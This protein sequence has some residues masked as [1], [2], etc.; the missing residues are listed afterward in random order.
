MPRASRTRGTAARSCCRAPPRRL[1]GDALPDGLRTVSLSGEHRLRDLGRPEALFQLAHP[2]LRR[3]FAPLRSLDAFPGNLPL[4]VSSFIGRE[5]DIARVIEALDE[6][7]IV[8]LTGVG[9]VGKTR[10]ALQSAAEVLPDFRDGAWVAELASADSPEALVQV[11]ATALRASPHPTTA[12]GRADT[13]TRCAT[14]S[15]CSCSTTASTFSTPRADSPR[16]SCGSVRAFG[17]WRRAASRSTSTANASCGSARCRCPIRRPTPN[18]RKQPTRCGCSSS[19]PAGAEPDFRWTRATCNVVVEICRRL[20]GIPLAIELA[21]ARVVSMSPDGDRGTPRRALPAAHRRTTHRGG[22]TSDAPS[23][24]RLVVLPAPTDGTLGVRS[25]RRV[26]RELRR[27]GG[28]RRH[29]GRRRRRLGRAGRTHQSREQVDGQHRERRRRHHA[30]PAP[31]DNAAVL[32][33]ATRP[34]G[35]RRSA[36]GGLTRSTTRSSPTTTATPCSPGHDI[37]RKQSNL[38]FEWDNYRAAVTWALDSDVPGD[39]DFALRIAVPMSGMTTGIRRAAGLIARTDQLLQRAE[40]STPAFRADVLAGMAN[41][42]LMLRGDVVAAADLARRAL[43]QGPASMAGRGHVVRDAQHLRRS[44]WPVP[45]ARSRSSRRGKRASDALSADNLNTE[46]V[47]RTLDRP[48]RRLPRRSKL[49]ATPRGGGGAT[50]PGCEV[51]HATR[52]GAH[53]PGLEEPLRRRRG[54]APGGGRSGRR[55]HGSRASRARLPRRSCA[56]PSWPAWPATR[57]RQSSCCGTPSIAWG[58]DISSIGRRERGRSCLS[59]LRAAVAISA[60]RRCW[61]DTPT[62]GMFSHLLLAT[63]STRAPAT[64]SGDELDGMLARD[65]RR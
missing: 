51:S 62:A 47:L 5:E 2:D 12:L 64:T 55:R 32:A 8:T 54:R 34:D 6:A 27:G 20:D 65:A 28:V 11:V 36:C 21:A 40:S 61:A 52:A 29:A 60:P 30:L 59:D 14:S 22:T 57:A 35:R 7:R 38:R 53:H 4:Q 58:D 44:R 26:S 24:G 16:G 39:G 9:G 3:D 49:G 42:A 33:R 31:R 41:D 10:L 46:S 15:S 19:A 25:A 43:D 17:S 23:D 63:R 37:Q 13:S 45:S 56:K 1:V 18:A 48:R 50:R